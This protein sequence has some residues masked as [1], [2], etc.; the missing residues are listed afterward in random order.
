MSKVGG[1]R[2]GVPRTTTGGSGKFSPPKEGNPLKP[3]SLESS[4][5]DKLTSELK[6]LKLEQKIAKL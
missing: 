4:N 5:V 6:V 2:D 1:V 3:T